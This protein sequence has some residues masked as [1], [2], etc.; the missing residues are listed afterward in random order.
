MIYVHKT[1]CKIHTE[2]GLRHTFVFC[3]SPRFDLS[4]TAIL[5]TNV[6]SLIYMY[7]NYF[8]S[9]MVAGRELSCVNLKEN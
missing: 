8:V 3:F 7:V 6:F 2:L 5:N 1:R 9:G 4:K